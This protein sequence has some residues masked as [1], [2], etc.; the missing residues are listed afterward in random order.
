MAMNEMKRQLFEQE[1]WIHRL[2][3]LSGLVYMLSNSLQAV[4]MDGKDDYINAVGYISSSLSETELA[5]K[6]LSEE[7]FISFRGWK[8]QTYAFLQEYPV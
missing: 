8:A 2:S 7:M 4:E 5:L 6:Q 1:R 3:A